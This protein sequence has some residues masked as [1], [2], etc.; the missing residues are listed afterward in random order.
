MLD[1]LTNTAVV[2]P[3]M[4]ARFAELGATVLSGSPADFEKANAPLV[5]ILER[6]PQH[7]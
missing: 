2:D 4:E 7:G 5:F 3:G 6:V 1:K